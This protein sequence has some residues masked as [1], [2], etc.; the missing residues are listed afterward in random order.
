[1]EFAVDDE[2]VEALAD[3][4]I[5]VVAVEAIP[6]YVVVGGV[7]E[8]SCPD[9]CMGRET[10][11]SFFLRQNAPSKMRRRLPSQIRFSTKRTRGFEDLKG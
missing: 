2:T 1:M 11:G 9:I 8:A 10:C 4:M 6:S 3:E 5:F 7:E